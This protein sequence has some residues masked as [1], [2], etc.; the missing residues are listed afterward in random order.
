MKSLIV[1]TCLGLLSL[2]TGFAQTS[3]DKS[4]DKS[5]EA[6]PPSFSSQAVPAG[7]TARYIVTYIKSNTTSGFRTASVVSVTNN[8]SVTCSI[9]VD[10]FAGLTG[11]SSGS[12]TTNLSVAAGNT[13]DFCSRNV[14]SG[15]TSCNSTCSPA[16]TFLEGRAQVAST[17]DAAG[18]CAGLAVESRVYYLTGTT[19]DTGVAAV[20][21][22][23]I[24]RVG[25]SNK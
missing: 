17:A 10:W 8:S 20:S 11:G 21:N 14:P 22:P 3:S 4:D 15:V 19:T 23:N 1:L 7:Q 25:E 16:Q 2:S 13:V 9:S 18:K 24:I 12:C 5:D 6:P